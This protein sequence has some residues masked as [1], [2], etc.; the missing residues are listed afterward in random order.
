MLQPQHLAIEHVLQAWIRGA[1]V[2]NPRV[3]DTTPGTSFQAE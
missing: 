2:V 3:G 1:W